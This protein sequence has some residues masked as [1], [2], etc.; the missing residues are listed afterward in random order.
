MKTTANG[1]YVLIETE[2]IDEKSSGGIVLPDAYVQKEQGGCD[3]G[4][5]RGIGPICYAGYNGMEECRN[6]EERAAV[7]G[8]KVGDQVQFDRYD[9]KI[10]EVEGYENFRLIA[11]AKI[12][13]R[14]G[15]DHE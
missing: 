14:I 1:Y 8:F 10:L 7:W 11:D 4:T 6:A 9:G 2:V 12:M 5:V 3:R 15:D 13:A